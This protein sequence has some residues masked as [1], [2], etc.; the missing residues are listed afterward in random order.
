MELFMQLESAW[1]VFM[2]VCAAIIAVGGAVAIIVRLYNWQRKPSREN[3]EALETFETY[4][5]SDK[6]RIETLE[7]RQEETSVQNKMMLRALVT[8]L[9]H[10][11]DGNHVDKLTEVRDEIEDYLYDAKRP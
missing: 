8:L 4:L 2:G 6:R 10:E 11:I 7:C 3:Q 9:G 1:A 5:A